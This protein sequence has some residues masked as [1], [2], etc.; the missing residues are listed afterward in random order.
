M[1]EAQRWTH[2]P[3]DLLKPS[4]R[5]PAG[6]KLPSPT[7]AE[8]SRANALGLDALPPVVVWPE[9]SNGRYEILAGIRTWRLAQEL[10]EEKVP[11]KWAPRS[12]TIAEDLVGT[13]YTSRGSD[14]ARLEAVLAAYDEGYGERPAD[15][16]RRL[17]LDRTLVSHLTR[18][19]RLV[20]SVLEE[21]RNGRLSI[22]HARLLAGQDEANQRRWCTKTL[23]G[24][25]SVHR[26]AAALRQEAPEP[27]PQISRPVQMDPNVRRLMEA[28]GQY[29]GAPVELQQDANGGRLVI[30]YANNDVLEGILQR[31]GFEV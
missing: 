31:I 17:G 3:F 27:E 22:G 14:V 5:R 25:W 20:P 12:E 30:G 9:P 18:C 26:L 28:L 7:A 19:S 11:V 29:L 24:K 8:R 1:A 2:I 16:A 21:V 4:A 23:D 13:D 15:I 10:G 6:Q